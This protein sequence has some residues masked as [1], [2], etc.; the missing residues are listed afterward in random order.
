MWSPLRVGLFAAA[1]CSI[2]GQYAAATQ[3][4]DL[5]G[6]NSRS[7]S[8]TVR[9]SDGDQPAC[10]KP[11]LDKILSQYEC[12]IER[13]CY[14]ENLKLADALDICLSATCELSDYLGSQ[15]SYAGTCDKQPRNRARHTRELCW[16]MFTIATIVIAGRFVARMR[17]LGGS[18][19]GWDDY[20]A[21]MTY[22]LL[23]PTDI[24][25]ELEVRN[26]FGMDMYLLT[27]E[28]ILVL[29]K[30]F[31]V[32]EVLYALIIVMTKISLVLLY[33][34]IW[35]ADSVTRN[36]RRSC[37]ALVAVLAAF[38]L[39][40]FLALV[41]QC[42]PVNYVWL[43]VTG[44]EG[45]C[46]NLEA[47]I[48]AHGAI[49]VCFDIVVILLPIHVLTKMKLPYT[50]KAGLSAVFLVGFLVTI[51][52]LIRLQYASLAVKTKNPTWDLHP[53][54]T[55]SLIEANFSVVVCC[56]PALTGLIQRTWTKSF[57]TPPQMGYSM[58][59]G[60]EAW[61]ERS[62][63]AVRPSTNPEM[64]LEQWESDAE[65]NRKTQIEDQ[66]TK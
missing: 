29:M 44:I 37:W 45:T 18:G 23:V 46:I 41:L 58:V 34:R 4:Q 52:S 39:S 51:C 40:G 64:V 20:V 42:N 3:H 21:F 59:S 49:N 60:D 53:I 9:V 31:Y 2:N 25:S 63:S 32:G 6:R 24:T 13:P 8:I 27:M 66:V 17:S 61:Q 28:Q 36:F 43:Q 62:R 26:G 47:L 38:C 12:S 56:M 33:L 65:R 19:F 50:K 30:S 1:I 15:R 11:C 10:V 57:G 55:W 22:A 54:G 35:P 48:Y 14:C 7:A 5:D 16:S